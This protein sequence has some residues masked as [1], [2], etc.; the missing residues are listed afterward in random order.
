V[1]RHGGPGL[2]LPLRHDPVG[3]ARRAVA[4]VTA[5]SAASAGVATATIASTGRPSRA[6]SQVPS[7]SP[8]GPAGGRGRSPRA[9][10]TPATATTASAARTTRLLR[11]SPSPVG[12]ATSTQGLA[13]ARSSDG[14]IPIVVPPPPLAPR[15]AAA[16]A[17]AEPSGD[18]DHPPAGQLEADLLGEPARLVVGLSAPRDRDVN[19]V[20]SHRCTLSGHYGY[21]APTC[22]NWLTS[23]R[24]EAAGNRRAG[25]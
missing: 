11:P 12:T 20:A 1:A 16:M 8:A 22:A 10:R 15:H 19:R 14:R 21:T 25:G 4:M 24:H 17:P 5:L 6:S 23:A 3:G 2:R 13:S 18:D 7:R 9:S